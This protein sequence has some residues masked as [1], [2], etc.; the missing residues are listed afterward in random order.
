MKKFLIITVLSL[1]IVF[2]GLSR[3]YA[4]GLGPY[5]ESGSGS[6][7]WETMTDDFDY[8]TSVDTSSFG[9]GFVLDTSPRDSKVF[10]YRLNIGY[11]KHDIELPVGGTIELNGLSIDNTF[12]FSI[13]RKKN[14]RLWLGPQ[15]RLGYYT[16]NEEYS[17]NY[18][19]DYTL[20]AFGL[21]PVLGVNFGMGS[22][23]VISI[24]RGYRFLGYAGTEDYTIDSIYVPEDGTNDITIAGGMGFLNASFLFGR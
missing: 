8:S 6:G 14:I 19:A 13:V 4:I 15:I 23:G 24:S 20:F 1:L 22:V 2:I 18:S 5:I 9:F 16:G 3:V 17:S 11:E 12:G 7:N 10:N 21:G